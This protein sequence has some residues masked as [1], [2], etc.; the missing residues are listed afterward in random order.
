LDDDGIPDGDF[1][2]KLLFTISNYEFDGFGGMW[3]P[4]ADGKVPKWIPKEVTTMRLL[5]KEIKVLPKGTTVAAGIC[6]FKRT[7]VLNAGCFPTQIGPKN[8]KMGYGEED[9]LQNKIWKAGGIIG[10]NPFWSMKHYVADY[11]FNLSWNLKRYYLKGRDSASYLLDVSPFKKIIVLIKILIIPAYLLIKN[12]PRV[13][14]DKNYF[15]QQLVLDCFKFSYSEFGRL[16]S[17]KKY[18]ND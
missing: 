17:K 18:I 6:A 13:F 4:Y 8:G 3:Y 10:F 16:I 9:F 12:I 2:D 1:V 11:K 14:F 5:T 15:W 7:V